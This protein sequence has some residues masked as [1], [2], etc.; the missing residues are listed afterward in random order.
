[1]RI[2]L[3]L[4][5]GNSPKIVLKGVDF[6]RLLLSEVSQALPADTP[7]PAAHLPLYC[8]TARIAFS[9]YCCAR[10]LC[11]S[12][13]TKTLAQKVRR[14]PLLLHSLLCL[15]WLPCSLVQSR[16]HSTC[17]SSEMQV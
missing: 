13:P 8:S 11:L 6:Y 15:Q 17:L 7:S 14:H 10:T 1:M 5:S 2:A 12:T 16:R 9:A 4:G 3:T